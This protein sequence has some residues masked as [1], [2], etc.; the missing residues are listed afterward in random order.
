MRKTVF[1]LNAW[2]KMATLKTEERGKGS[3][4]SQAPT[5]ENLEFV[6][7]NGDRAFAFYPMLVLLPTKIGSVP[8]KQCC[9]GYSV[10]SLSSSSCKVVLTLLT[11]VIALHVGLFTIHIWEP[12]LERTF[13]DPSGTGTWASKTV[14]RMRCRSS[15]IYLAMEG[16][17]GAFEAA[18][19]DEGQGAGSS[20]APTGPESLWWSLKAWDVDL[21][22]TGPERAEDTWPGFLRGRPQA[23]KAITIGRKGM[24]ES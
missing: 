8:D 6:P 7:S 11:E 14:F 17:I 22:D 20:G 15:L 13:R 19:A 4:F 2:I 16:A 18:G 12:G 23:L 10:W 9:K 24:D 3:G 1:C 5:K 21:K